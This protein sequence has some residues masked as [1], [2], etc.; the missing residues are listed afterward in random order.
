MTTPQD[1]RNATAW[2]TYT[3]N[4]ILHASQLALQD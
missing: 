1:A 3:M 4:G 2:R